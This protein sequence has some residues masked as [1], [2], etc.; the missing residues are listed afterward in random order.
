MEEKNIKMPF[1]TPEGFF[2]ESKAMALEGAMKLR[3]RRRAALGFAAA[4]CLAVSALLFVPDR[5]VDASYDNC[6]D[7]ILAELV[8]M[9]D[10]D[11]YYDYQLLSE[12]E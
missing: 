7:D 5:T 6:P 10:L 2:E 8:A 3:N 9:N 4:G 1:T 12:Q 11:A